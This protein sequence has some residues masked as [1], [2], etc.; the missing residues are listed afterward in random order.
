MHIV[1]DTNVLVSALLSPAGKPA[2]ILKRF[3]GGEFTLCY[4]GRIMLEY[5]AVLSRPKFG[6]DPTKVKAILDYIRW[7]GVQVE[8]P[9]LDIVFADEFDKKFYEVAKCAG[10]VLITGNLKHFPEDP[11]V[12]GVHDV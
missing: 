5:E 4:D 9:A 2:Q 10:A 7:V 1:L 6:F 12:K 3:L 11:I 8:A